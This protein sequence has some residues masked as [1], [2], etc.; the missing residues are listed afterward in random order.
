VSVSFYGRTADGESVVLD[1]EDGAFLNM[2]SANARA[3]LEFLGL[4]PGE[5]PSGEVAMPEAR[6]ALIRTRATF[7][8]RVGS[9]TRAPSD[10]K[11]PGQCRLHMG[12]IDEE[13]LAG[14]ID[15]F[16]RFIGAVAELG[17]TSIY[18]G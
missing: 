11:R 8:R 12:G 15:D 2:S 10:T 6:S 4:E 5:E 13:Y 9:Y 18:W 14:R 7:D 1:H 17:A 16:E 3:V